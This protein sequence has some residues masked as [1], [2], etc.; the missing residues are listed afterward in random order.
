MPFQINSP[1][2]T[3]S[4]QHKPHT[5]RYAYKT[6]EEQTT[7][8]GHL[9]RLVG[10]NGILLGKEG[11][12]FVIHH[13]VIPA[14]ALV[15]FLPL[16]PN[17][18]YGKN[19]VVREE[20]QSL[21]NRWIEAVH[22]LYPEK[23]GLHP[24]FAISPKELERALVLCPLI[25]RMLFVKP[26]GRYII[27][28]SRVVTDLAPLESV[29]SSEVLPLFISLEKGLCGDYGGSKL[30]NGLPD[31]FEAWKKNGYQGDLFRFSGF[32]DDDNLER[33]FLGQSILSMIHR[34]TR[35]R[36]DDDDDE[37]GNEEKA[38]KKA[39]V[40]DEIKVDDTTVPKAE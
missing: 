13:T 28:T 23:I 5:I 19:T 32:H 9:V 6:K 25:E 35:S 3:M 17:S 1:Q 33:R 16:K 36:P 20:T 39:K 26:A 22:S 21:V 30:E 15:P 24:S 10:E 2:F 7:T 8:Y 27:A 34:I 12:E 11:D 40:V 38:K 31:E 4:H 18:D 37:E 29:W 14:H